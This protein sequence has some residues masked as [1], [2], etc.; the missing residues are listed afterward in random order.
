MASPFDNNPQLQY[1][2]R[3]AQKAG[4]TEKD[5]AMY[6]AQRRNYDYD[7][8]R[9]A[10]LSDADVISYNI[11][12]VNDAGAFGAF[13]QEAVPAVL[14]AP[15]VGYG[16]AK[17]FQ[18][19]L[20]V[21]GP[22]PV[23]IGAGLLGGL[24]GAVVPSAIGAGI[25]EE[26]EER[27]GLDGQ[28]LPSSQKGAVAGQTFGFISGL[29]LPTV[30]R[31][32]A[33]NV[34]GTKLGSALG[35]KPL[36]PEVQAGGDAFLQAGVKRSNLGSA[37][38]LDA[39]TKNP[40]M[41]SAYTRVGKKLKGFETKLDTSKA[42]RLADP[43]I[44]L[45][46]DVGIAGGAALGAGIAESVAPD[47]LLVRMAGE[48]VGGVVNVTNLLNRVG[49]G[50]SRF[51]RGA[52][53]KAATGP[54]AEEGR[55]VAQLEKMINDIDAAAVGA[56][57]READAVAAIESKAKRKFVE[58]DYSKL[59]DVRIDVKKLIDDL[60]AADPAVFKIAKGERP[61]LN[62]VEKT[63]D[64]FMRLLGSTLM[65][66]R[67]GESN[68]LQKNVIATSKKAAQDMGAILDQ[69]SFIDNPAILS[70][71]SRLKE[72]NFVALMEGTLNAHTLKAIDKA[73]LIG[74]R[75]QN[76]ARSALKVTGAEPT[77]V[78]FTGGGEFIG[79]PTNAAKTIIDTI[80]RASDESRKIE[81]QLWNKVLKTTEVPINNVINFWERETKPSGEFL[82]QGGLTANK[83]LY[84][85]YVNNWFNEIKA[86]PNK[87][88][89]AVQNKIGDVLARIKE[90][91]SFL[92]PSG[93][94]TSKLKE[95][96]AQIPAQDPETRSYLEY[97]IDLFDTQIKYPQGMESQ[98]PSV[99]RNKKILSKELLE[100]TKKD[101]VAASRDELT[102][103]EQELEEIPITTTFGRLQEFRS[104]MLKNSRV[105]DATEVG[106]SQSGFYAKL[107]EKALDDMDSDVVQA[108]LQPKDR[109]NY[110]TARAFS[111]AFNDVFTRAYGGDLLRSTTSGADRVTPEKLANQLITS[112][113][114]ETVQRFNQ[115]DNAM[116]F[117]IQR[118]T[119][120]A[121][122]A[123]MQALKK[124][125]L[126]G[127]E[128]IIL[129]DIIS[130]KVVDPTTNEIKMGPF[131]TVLRDY[132]EVF[133]LP[134]LK[135]LGA[136]L[137]DAKKAQTAL[138]AI[139]RDIGVSGYQIDKGSDPGNLTVQPRAKKPA[140][141][142][143]FETP[144]FQQRGKDIDS[145]RVFLDNRESPTTEIIKIRTQDKNPEETFTGLVN[146]VNRSKRDVE[147]SPVVGLRQVTLDAAVES[148]RR[149]DGTLD[150][151]KFKNFLLEPMRSKNSKSLAEFFLE[152]NVLTDKQFNDLNTLVTFGERTQRI[153]NS[154]DAPDAIIADLLESGNMLAAAAG[155]AAGSTAF[156]TALNTIYQRLPFEVRRVSI[157]EGG[158]GAALA[159]KYL[160]QLP[161]Q[162]V[163]EILF[164]SVF[165]RGK[166]NTDKMAALLKQ[167][168]T[169]DDIRN[170]NRVQRPLLESILGLEGY[171]EVTELI[172]S[173]DFFD[174]ATTPTRTIEP[175]AEPS[176][177]LV[178][179]PESETN[180]L[181]PP[182]TNAPTAP[183][184][185]PST[186]VNRQA[187]AAMFPFDTASEVIRS[188][189]GIGSL[190]T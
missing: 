86:I 24:I 159:G 155:R 124:Y 101:L 18:T 133:A 1:D 168:R 93:A 100:L 49:S 12:D 147:G 184:P 106:A 2:L 23:K 188:Q 152:K 156:S 139:K 28:Y 146:L 142:G 109:I 8:A 153:I 16:M 67:G 25:T 129:R 69:L 7:A 40:S 185:A 149:E 95:I 108:A 167:I 73:N 107:A 116:D 39:V 50:V 175:V 140:R 80:T 37:V 31:G 90:P 165:G 34:A 112:A 11:A 46:K 91:D 35:F 75:M 74:E 187:Y 13:V 119:D 83:A 97:Q 120:P 104:Q 170:F 27:I 92:A 148:A 113:G 162:A 62:S 61:N 47:N 190:M 52:M 110:D 5:I 172:N 55:V 45:G 22:L 71:V 150:F 3:E 117:I 54:A 115:L 88:R 103:L 181:L 161:Y 58:P 180:F 20:K 53:R 99:Q 102:V 135:R 189:E 33:S 127:A 79:S 160:D 38:F 30:A 26:V 105:T 56:A 186:P 137:R 145:F 164:D 41:A 173:D 10:G 178:Q 169:P 44:G 166:E 171:R 43:L 6:A 36:G 118:Q 57:R 65:S 85:P 126:R 128:E 9:K 89:V 77:D 21:P 78:T 125:D 51:V 158:L 174:Y 63:N 59:N 177:P 29:G 157:I 182:P 123:E 42:A 66:M 138:N 132:E 17:G 15:A 141:K 76:S 183:P 82:E 136:D 96:R 176:K 72:D 144:L 130:K 134:Q 179:L 68:S 154:K 87:D 32:V 122:K 111:K 94:D 131:N 114:N 14:T 121:L 48:V 84:I 60:E 143:T 81:K 98:I 4:L 19:G 64:T 151:T 70:L 163:Q